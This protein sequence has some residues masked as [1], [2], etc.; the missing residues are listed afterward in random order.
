MSASGPSG[1]LVYVYWQPSELAI[2]LRKMKAG[3]SLYTR[4]G[5]FSFNFGDRHGAN[6]HAGLGCT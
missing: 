5:F 6:A 2:N 3:E 1:P 4:P